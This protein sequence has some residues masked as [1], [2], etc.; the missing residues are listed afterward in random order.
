MAR[1]MRENTR[2]GA[3][4]PHRPAINLRLFKAPRHRISL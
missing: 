2:I 4:I 3:A 1:K